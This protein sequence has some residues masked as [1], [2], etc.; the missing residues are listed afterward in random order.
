MAEHKKILCVHQG[1]ELYGS[2]RVFI[3]SVKAFRQQWPD[4]LITVHL[5]KRGILSDKLD[6]YCD[7]VITGDISIIRKN[8]FNLLSIMHFIKNVLLNYKTV[9]GYDLV[10]LNTGL[11][12]S[13]NFLTL[14]SKK[15]LLH[16]HEIPTG[17]AKVYFYFLTFLTRAK[18]IGNSKATAKAIGRGQV[19]YN[20]IINR[21]KQVNKR[22]SSEGL[23]VLLIGRINSW[24]G[25]EI[26]IEAVNILKNNGLKDIKLKFAGSYFAEQQIF[27]DRLKEKITELDLQDQVIF[28]NFANDPQLY[29]Q[30]ADLVIVPSIKPEPF[31]LVAVEA[32][33][34][35]L[36]VIAANHGGL[37]E[38][39]QHQETGLLFAPGSASELA[40]AIETY[41]DDRSLLEQ[42]GKQGRERFLKHFQE[43]T[44]M[45]NF[46]KEVKSYAG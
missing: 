4:A 28:E 26:A 44:Y 11:I 21:P 34:A 40:K 17:A 30:W 29:Y 27:L 33:R 22:Y 36:P 31:G 6:Q 20:G 35:S 25:H 5:P 37:P 1:W 2:D 45:E 32:M 38:I 13:Y 3:Q 15:Y 7:H 19:V 18:I 10:Y 41:Y 23:N 39:V 8:S 43:Q 24:K 12:S 42:H 16:I 14:F 9:K 46:I